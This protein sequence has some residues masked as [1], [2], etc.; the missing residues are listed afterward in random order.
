[1]DGRELFFLNLE[2]RTDGR[3][4]FREGVQTH[5]YFRELGRSDTKSQQNLGKI[6]RNFGKIDKI[7]KID[8]KINRICKNRYDFGRI[9]T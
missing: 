7:C 3:Q 8:S 9:D 6:S 2:D 4:L 5:V 1:M